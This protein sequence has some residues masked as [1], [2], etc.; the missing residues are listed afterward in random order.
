MFKITQALCPGILW[1]Y[2]Q[3][4]ALI[5]YGDRISPLATETLQVSARNKAFSRLRN[6]WGTRTVL[7]ANLLLRHIR[8]PTDN[9]ASCQM[10]W[11]LNLWISI[12]LLK[13]KRDVRDLNPRALGQTENDG[14]E[15]SL[16]QEQQ[17]KCQ[18]W[19]L[20]K[21]EVVKWNNSSDLLSKMFLNYSLNMSG[22]Q[23][24]RCSV[25]FWW[26]SWLRSATQEGLDR[27]N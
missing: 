14:W 13:K 2:T 9:K 1:Y 16:G 8:E 19:S 6:P 17:M 27:T 10:R 23:R 20:N 25:D 21:W 26:V 22:A 5:K 3:N 4:P 12:T 7:H 15:K 11:P 18:K 24:G